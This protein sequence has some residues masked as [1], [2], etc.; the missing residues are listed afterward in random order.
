[1][2]RFGQLL[3]RG[4]EYIAQGDFEK[5]YTDLHMASQIDPKNKELQQLLTDVRHRNDASRL[6]D[7][8]AKAV[9][10]EK[11][12]DFD[13]ALVAYRGAANIDAKNATAAYK[14]GLYLLKLGHDLKDAKAHA[15]RV[16]ELEPRNADGH[17]LLGMILL[18]ADLKK[19]AKKQFEEAVKI[20]EEHVEANA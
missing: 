11:A 5:A 10:A 2:S 20:D 4:K 18:K 15:Q 12:G 6:T 14:S 3:V 19:S 7:E 1:T 17:C 16:V 8:L 9:K 13:A